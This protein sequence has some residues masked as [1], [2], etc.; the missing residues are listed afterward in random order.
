MGLV[1]ENAEAEHSLADEEE[2]PA[3]EADLPQFTWFCK[4]KYCEGN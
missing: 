4:G 3:E 1:V 2:N